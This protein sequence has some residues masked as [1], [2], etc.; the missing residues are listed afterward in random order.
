MEPTDVGWGF[1]PYVDTAPNPASIIRVGFCM[2]CG[3]LTMTPH[4]VCPMMVRYV[5]K[6][7]QMVIGGMTY[8]EILI[9]QARWN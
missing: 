4:S 7:H 9:V 6:D 3:Y 5:T 1:R 8:D 2:G